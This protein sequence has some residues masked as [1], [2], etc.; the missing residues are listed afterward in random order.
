MSRRKRPN[1]S[2]LSKRPARRRYVWKKIV[3][4]ASVQAALLAFD[5][6]SR[7]QRMA[8]AREEIGGIRWTKLKRGKLRILV[9]VENG[10]ILWNA[11]QRKE[12][13]AGLGGGRE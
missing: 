1:G 7:E 12:Y 5:H 2:L 9:W 6:M 11:Y 4:V 10:R 3:K 8:H 13:H